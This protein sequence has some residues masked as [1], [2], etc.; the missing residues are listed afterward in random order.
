MTKARGI[1]ADIPATVMKQDH[2][3]AS[4][5][6]PDIRGVATT[7]QEHKVLT[8]PGAIAYLCVGGPAA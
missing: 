4:L 2:Q 8:T 1:L 6:Q 7:R 3:N 5:T